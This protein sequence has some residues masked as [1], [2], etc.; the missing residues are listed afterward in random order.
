MDFTKILCLALA[1]GYVSS[2]PPPLN[3]RFNIY[4][5]GQNN[6]VDPASFDLPP[7]NNIRVD[8]YDKAHQRAVIGAMRL[9]LENLL[10]RA[11]VF[12]QHFWDPSYPGENPTPN[13]VVF[14]RYMTLQEFLRQFNLTFEQAEWFL[15]IIITRDMLQRTIR[16][17]VEYHATNRGRNDQ[18]HTLQFR[19]FGL[20]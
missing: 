16:V 6:F 11:Q 4:V 1:I 20:D 14:D 2:E 8:T 19:I 15:N 13:Y 3:R 5:G 9:P 7:I 10:Y 18:H 12:N 17:K